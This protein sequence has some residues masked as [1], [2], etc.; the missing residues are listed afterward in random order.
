MSSIN[1]YEYAV[2]VKHTL[3]LTSYDMGA[4]SLS[5]GRRQF[6]FCRSEAASAGN[7]RLPVELIYI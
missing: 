3:N 1:E 4:R 7:T 6:F 2:V 5:V